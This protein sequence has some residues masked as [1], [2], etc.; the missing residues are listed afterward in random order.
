[1]QKDKRG[2]RLATLQESTP[3]LSAVDNVD[4]SKDELT[5]IPHNSQFTPR[6]LEIL[7]FLYEKQSRRMV[8]IGFKRG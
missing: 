8:C 5:H 1:M 2:Q 3:L 4:N 7:S 6:F